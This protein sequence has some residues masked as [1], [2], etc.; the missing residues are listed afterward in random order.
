ML[1]DDDSVIEF[2]IFQEDKIELYVVC[3]LYTYNAHSTVS[4]HHNTVLVNTFMLCPN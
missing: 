4:Q 2:S 3:A 1:I